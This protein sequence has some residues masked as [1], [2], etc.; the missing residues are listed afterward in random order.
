MDL[1]GFEPPT[2]RSTTEL[3]ARKLGAH[4]SA[5]INAAV[6]GVTLTTAT[7]RSLT[8]TEVTA[9]VV[10]TVALLLALLMQSGTFIA[11]MLTTGQRNLF[12]VS[13]VADGLH[14]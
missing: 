11:P 8:T 13:V 7:P 1:E 5:I 10:T 9:S 2:K 12:T 6:A 14:S 3:Q 4:T